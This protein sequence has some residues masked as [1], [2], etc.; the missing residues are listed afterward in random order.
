MQSLM[1]IQSL[2]ILSIINDAINNCFL[3]QY[4]TSATPARCYVLVLTRIRSPSTY[5]TY[6]GENI[7]LLLSDNSC[8]YD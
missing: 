6:V 7:L 4:T 3:L 2:M 5:V 1:K 8:R